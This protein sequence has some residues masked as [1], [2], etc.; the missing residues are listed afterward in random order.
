MQGSGIIFVSMY[1]TKSQLISIITGKDVSYAG[2]Y[3]ET[4]INDSKRTLVNL[5]SIY[6]GTRVKWIPL[7]YTLDSL[8]KNP[9]TNKII[10][11]P[12]KGEYSGFH[13]LIVNAPRYRIESNILEV[14]RKLLLES[15]G[16]TYNGEFITT[17]YYIIN[18]ALCS[19]T[20]GQYSQEAL[21]KGVISTPW[22]GKS[23]TIDRGVINEDIKNQAII[24]INRQCDDDI[25]NL[26]STFL[27][28]TEESENFRCKCKDVSNKIKS[29]N[30]RLDKDAKVGLDIPVMSTRSDSNLDKV[31]SKDLIKLGSCEYNNKAP[32]SI[33]EI[34]VQLSNITR[35]NTNTSVI[36][37]LNKMIETFNIAYPESI[38]SPPVKGSH[39]AIISSGPINKY[40]TMKVDNITYKL[41]LK[42][43]SFSAFNDLQLKEIII[44]LESMFQED[45]CINNLKKEAI[46][47]LSNRNK[48]KSGN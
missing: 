15:V 19:L 27:Q 22:V 6:D 13:G 12:F 18:K 42:G 4:I 21:N 25:I 31:Y 29:L 14:Y 46:I 44:Q 3:H 38:I 26:I 8:I 33:R 34:F 10:L 45:K 5:F 9:A 41:P 16:M 40:T 36:I 23:F 2:F 24:Y 1:D 17:A 39:S 11:R 32:E 48:I 37:D 30:I 28:L 35:K 20:T 47:E 7:E 43:A